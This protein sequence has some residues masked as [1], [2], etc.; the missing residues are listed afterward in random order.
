[1]YAMIIDTETNGIDPETCDLLEFGWASI[2]CVTGSLLDCGS[3]RVYHEAVDVGPVDIHGITP[4][5]MQDV[6]SEAPC[7]AAWL[8]WTWESTEAESPMFLIAHN[9]S[10][11]RRVLERRGLYPEIPWVCTYE[12]FRWP[13][14]DKP[15]RQVDLALRLGVGVTTAHRAINDVLTLQRCLERAADLY[16]DHAL[17][18]RFETALSERMVEVVALVSY[19][20]RAVARD[21]GFRWDAV[22]RQWTRRMRESDVPALGF[23]VRPVRQ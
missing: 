15:L 21:A 4:R 12:Q 14:I 9:A 20:N 5:M 11:D 22:A 17:E 1:M 23:P 18:P 13:G 6:W 10:F 19:D 3:W 2:D 16:A 8:N 7:P